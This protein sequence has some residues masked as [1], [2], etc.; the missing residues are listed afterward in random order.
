[1]PSF[2]YGVTQDDLVTPK[3]LPSTTGKSLGVK[4]IVFKELSLLPALF[5]GKNTI[6]VKFSLLFGLLAN[7]YL[8][9][10]HGCLHIYDK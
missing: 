10:H 7:E 9:R 1:M 6:C 4:T 2:Y 5:R 3:K 8:L